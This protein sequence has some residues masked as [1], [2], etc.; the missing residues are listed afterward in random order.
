MH[1]MPYW[2]SKISCNLD[3]FEYLSFEKQVRIEDDAE[4]PSGGRRG[5]CVMLVSHQVSQWVHYAQPS[6]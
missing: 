2:S 5:G 3:T 4:T 6:V 1:Q